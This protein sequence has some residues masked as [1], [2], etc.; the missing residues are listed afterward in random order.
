MVRPEPGRAS[1]TVPACRWSGTAR[2]FQAECQA[3]FPLGWI[4]FYLRRPALPA[5]ATHDEGFAE[6]K[7]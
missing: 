1:K 5:L 3:L 2:F 7:K 6:K 4:Q